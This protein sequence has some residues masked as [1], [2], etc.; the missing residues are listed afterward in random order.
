MF[1]VTRPIFDKLYEILVSNYDLNSTVLMTSI[2]SLRMF[3]WTLG[4][5]QSISQVEN[6]F[7]KSTETISR[8][9]T[10]V[11][12]CVFKLGEHII[13]PRIHNLLKYILDWRMSGSHH[14]LMVA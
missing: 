5:P 13:K 3:L 4:G 10:E 2:E 1:R 12:E 7:E 11:L 9:F 14:I 8:K 6:R